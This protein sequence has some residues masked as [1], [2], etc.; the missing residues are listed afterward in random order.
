M[1]RFIE[2][3]SFGLQLFLN[4]KKWLKHNYIWSSQN[5]P[6]ALKNWAYNWALNVFVK[7]N[8]SI[9]FSTET[10]LACYVDLDQK[11]PIEINTS[12]LS[13]LEIKSLTF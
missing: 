10:E 9:L 11:S 8:C 4:V 6:A 12:Q 1:Y 13:V 5:E 2:K 3:C 7:Y